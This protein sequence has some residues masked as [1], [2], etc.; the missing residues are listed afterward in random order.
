MKLLAFPR[1]NWTWDQFQQKTP[2]QS[3]GLDGIV[4]EGP[5]YD[6]ETLHINFDHHD[7][8]VRSATMSTAKQVM[9][10]IKE[11]LT[12]SFPDP[13]VYVNDPDQDTALA[14]FLLQ[15]PTFFQGTNSNPLL[16]RL[17][18]L[19]DE[20]DIT[21]GSFPRNLNEQL[22]KQHAWIFKP[23]TE[24]RTSGALSKATPGIV[25]DNISATNER[26]M[27]YLM[28]RG[29]EID[30]DTR[31][32]ILYQSPHGYTVYN[33][34]GG[35]DARYYLFSKGMQAFVAY[36]G[37]Q[38]DKHKYSIGK[39]RFSPFPVTELYSHLNKIEGL[40]R[41]NVWG[42]SDLVG[43]S[44]RAIGSKLAPLEIAKEIDQYLKSTREE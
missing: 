6:A 37:P 30:L 22:M 19:T 40:E 21:G 42:G 7:N 13:N 10:A 25:L 3:I 15:N 32:E 26:I 39:F 36:L 4:L 41:P 43:G 38:G 16:S 14:V 35:N 11:G 23:Y 44:P 27:Q 9:F 33:E 28:G 31:H 20:L 1:E 24:L 5:R 34:I 2:R 18:S 8:V 12:S 29:K 17:L